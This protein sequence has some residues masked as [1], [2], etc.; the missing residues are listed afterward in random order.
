MNGR[1]SRNSIIANPVLVGAVTLLVVVVAVFL[2]YNAN[3][4]LPFVPTT[5][6]RVQA[7]N[8]ANLLPGNDVREGGFRIG[9]V[10]TMRPTRLPNGR[11][12]AEITLKLDQSAGAL[13]V[14]STIN[15]RPRSVLG[16]KYV[17]ITRGTSK[18]TFGN[19]E[20]LPA[21]QTR[22]PVDL[23]DLQRIYD[24]PTRTGVRRGLQGFG[25]ALAGRGGAL[26]QTIQDL[27]LLLKTLEPV[28]RSLAEPSTELAR[29]FRELGDTVRVVR[30]VADRYAHQ[31]TAAADV[32]EA[33]SRF[34]DR[35]GLAI[36]RS[37]P[38]LETAIRSQRVQRPFLRRLASFSTALDHAA[39]TLPRSLPR[40][41]PALETGIRVQGRAPLLNRPLK[42]T[43]AG[44][45]RLMVDPATGTAFRGLTVTGQTLNPILRFAGP[46]ITVCN[47][48]NYAWTHLGEILTEPDPTGFGQRVLLMQPPRT[49]NPV[50]PQL[51]SLG[52][53][54][55][56][57]GEAVLSGNP[58]NFHS[59]VY[60]RY[61]DAQ[62]NADCEAGQRGYLERVATFSK[63]D[64]KIVV[65][66]RTPGLQG[67][68]FTGL[69]RVPPGQTFVA[70][71]QGGPNP[72]PSIAPEQDP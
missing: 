5:T 56:A 29:L 62:G 15:L 53:A 16:L 69:T 63:P 4:G 52:A 14:D 50:D 38:T 49:V 2:S 58:V 20:T 68:T 65:D 11:T 8:G 33:W 47:Y 18:K 28:A 13:P 6:L 54:R 71:P 70:K 27:P 39:S 45:R 72:P 1:R 24:R 19:G 30:P 55:P 23:D 32:F 37:G 3:K 17:E 51:G 43:F 36:Q 34:P 9:L 40:I 31:F 42:A 60:G 61:V 48:F 26:N 35:L 7:E 67:P 66:P 59:N 57:N 12:G 10:D 64:Q 22:Y 25:G 21:A 46:S 41:I 44:L